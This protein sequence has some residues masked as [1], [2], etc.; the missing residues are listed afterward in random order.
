MDLTTGLF[1]GAFIF[2]I[3]TLA[4]WGGDAWDNYRI[5]RRR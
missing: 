1:W 3:L 2:G 5:R 4:A